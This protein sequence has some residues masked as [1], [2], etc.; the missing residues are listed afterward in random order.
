MLLRKR[1][2]RLHLADDQPSMEG[3]LVGKDADHYRLAAAKLLLENPDRTLE[4]QGEAWVPRSR[5]LYLQV[6]G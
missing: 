1:L 6:L 5:V 4:L 3:I 2:V